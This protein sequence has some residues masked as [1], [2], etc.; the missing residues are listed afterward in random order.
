MIVSCVAAAGADTAI[1]FDVAAIRLP[2]EKRSVRLPVVPAID[3]VKR[4]HAARVRCR[5][6]RA[7]ERTAAG[8]NRGRNGEIPS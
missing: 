3:I 1:A 4:R 6:R 5:G 8:R 2:E 7:A